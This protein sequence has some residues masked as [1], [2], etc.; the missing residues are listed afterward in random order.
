MSDQA[1]KASLTSPIWNWAV[2]NK[3]TIQAACT[4]AWTQ[5]GKVTIAE[6]YRNWMGSMRDGTVSL[7]PLNVM[8][9]ANNPRREQVQQVYN[10]ELAA[11]R[12]GQKTF[13]T[14]FTGPIKDNTGQTRIEG[15]PD[16]AAL[17]DQR[18]QWFVENVVGS[19]TP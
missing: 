18:G 7:A 16:V 11:F 10:D 1:P 17:Y 6:E 14:I 4:G 9:L 2:H 5:A 8:P 19:P 15:K 13:E 12:S 3:P